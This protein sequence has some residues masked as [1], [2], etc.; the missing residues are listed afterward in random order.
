MS[1]SCQSFNLIFRNKVVSKGCALVTIQVRDTEDER[2]LKSWT[3]VEKASRESS[4][5]V[6]ISSM[7][8]FTLAKNHIPIPVCQ[9]G[10]SSKALVVAEDCEGNLM[11]AVVSRDSLSESFTVIRRR[12]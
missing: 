12:T 2:L 1:Q 4:D 11:K 5:P 6:I 9:R 8:E 3:F 10:D 7:Q